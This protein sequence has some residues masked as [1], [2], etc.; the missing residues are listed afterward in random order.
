V[1]IF[2]SGGYIKRTDPSEYRTQRRGGVGVVDLDTKEEDFVKIFLTTN[3]HADILFFT[4]KGKAYQLKAYELPEGRRA[5]RGKS[6]MN[7]IQLAENENVTSMLAMPKEMKQAESMSLIM[8]TE[9]GVVKKTAA[10]AFRD[11][12]RN[13]LLAIKLQPDDQLLSAKFVEGKD[14]VS[15]VTRD[16]QS[17]RFKHSDVREMGRTAGGVRGMTL[18]GKDVIVTADVIKSS[19][20]SPLLIVISE[21]GYGKMTKLSEYKTQKRGGSGIKTSNV[22]AKTG[23]VVAG[24]VLP[25]QEGEIVAISKQSQ[26]IRVPLK[27]ISVSGRSTQGVRIMRLREGDSIASLTAL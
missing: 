24:M 9:R 23:K 26:V 19:Y 25:D 14:E 8:V 21:A 1:L 12:R 16:G 20:N 18:K 5:T 3:T 22:T 11:V 4:D 15:L 7:Y 13:G 2:S 10:D 6:I 27:E 17:I